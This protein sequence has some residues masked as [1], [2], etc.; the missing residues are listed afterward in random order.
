MTRHARWPDA[1]RLRYYLPKHDGWDS[2]VVK[3]V[4]YYWLPVRDD[5]A[6]DRVAKAIWR[7]L[8]DVA[9]EFGLELGSFRF[10]SELEALIRRRG[11]P[12][13]VHFGKQPMLWPS[14][15][16]R[17]FALAVA[18]RLAVSCHVHGDVR[19]ELGYLWRQRPGRAL[20]VWPIHSLSPVLLRTLRLVIVNSSTMARSVAAAGVSKPN[21][22]VLPNPVDVDYWSTASAEHHPQLS[23]T[24]F[25]F[26][27]GRLVNEKGFDLLIEAMSYAGCKDSLVI[28]GSGPA[29]RRLR[30]LAISRGVALELIGPQ[31]PETLRVHLRAARVAV[32]PS[33]YEPFSLAALE[34]ILGSRRA[35]VS[36][37]AGVLEFL[38]LRIRSSLSV[39]AAIPALTERLREQ[40][41][42]EY[43]LG[44]ATQ[45]F[46]PQNVARAF[47]TS[48]LEAMEA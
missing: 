1:A 13:L 25:V 45:I 23:T 33:R 39:D 38:P 8:Q 46:S 41:S 48:A 43:D 36:S 30:S 31:P 5:G 47:A 40:P 3:R 27:H 4:L 44:T 22:R 29:A 14:Q 32:Y 37:S 12:G 10:A 42:T 16:S 18:H 15:R 24:S 26:S 34:A 21:I 2:R 7:G 28:A 20:A 35:L 19:T 11:R 6:P 9:S 17:A